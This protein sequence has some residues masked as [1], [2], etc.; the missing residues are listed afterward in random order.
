MTR[1]V[2]DTGGANNKVYFNVK[3]VETTKR[4]HK[5]EGMA[6]AQGGVHGTEDVNGSEAVC[7]AQGFNHVAFFDNK[8]AVIH[9]G[10]SN[11]RRVSSA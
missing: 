9:T 10:F 1:S 4:A 2:D 11:K 8:E 5:I 7:D 3:G 6:M